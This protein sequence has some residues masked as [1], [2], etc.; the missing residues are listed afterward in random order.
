VLPDALAPADN[1]HRRD[2]RAGA[3][4]G[5]FNFDGTARFRRWKH[6]VEKGMTVSEICKKFVSLGRL[7]HA[8]AIAR[9]KFPRKAAAIPL[10]TDKLAAYT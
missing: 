4:S 2:D 3:M 8:I 7:A 10:V 1:G 6:Y 5:M 9:E